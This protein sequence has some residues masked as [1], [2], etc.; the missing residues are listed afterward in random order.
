CWEHYPEDGWDFLRAFYDA[1]SADPGIR[2]CTV[3]E[4]LAEHPPDQHLPS[5]FSGSWIGSDFTTW[6]GDPVKNRAWDLLGAARS[7]FAG[8]SGKDRDAI[9]E[10]LLTAEGSDWFWWFGAGHDSGQDEL[11]DLQFRLHL[12]N[13]YR[14]MGQEPPGSLDSA[15]T[16][17]ARP[18]PARQAAAPSGTFDAALPQGAMHAG[19]TTFSRFAF[20]SDGEFF[21]VEI[22]FGPTFEPGPTD[23][24]LI[25]TF[26]LGQ[27]RH[28]SPLNAR[29]TANLSGV[30]Y[31]FLYSHEIRIGFA[32]LSAALSEA[33][34]VYTWHELTKEMAVCRDGAKLHLDLPVAYLGLAPGR[35][36]HFVVALCRNGDLTEIQPSDRTLC[37]LVPRPVKTESQEK[38]TAT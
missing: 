8:Y 27:T 24:I 34:E 22:E 31:R 38:V 18:E 35:E 19:A 36:I 6:I 14:L 29:P 25:G 10:E 2:L 4:Y 16:P 26:Y 3:S 21:S 11:F 13:A 7:A 33:G 28:N 1:I 30:T 15:V 32:P 12:Q 5:L 37:V 20:Q 17:V 9:E 23:E